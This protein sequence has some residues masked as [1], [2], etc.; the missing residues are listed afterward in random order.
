MS[1]ENEK[2]VIDT[3]RQCQRNWDL[4]KEIPNEHIQHWKY[5]AKHSPSKQDEGYYNVRII[6][7]RELIDELKLH[8]WGQSVKV[9]DLKGVARNPQMGA[10]VYILFTEK[11]SETQREID[12]AGNP[13]DLKDI[14]KIKNASVAAGI[15]GGLIAQSAASLGYRIGFNTNHSEPEIWHSKL[16]ILASKEN[17]LFGIGIGFPQEDKPRNETDETE[18]YIDGYPGQEGYETG[19]PN[20]PEGTKGTL[21]R[22]GSR[23]IMHDG[24]EHFLPPTLNYTTFSHLTKE[25]KVWIYE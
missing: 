21:V 18:F 7:N 16:R 8:T 23:S 24:K 11:L 14:V 3:I 25:I 15:A 19:L 5:I 2:R 12:I 9:G 13:I 17:L 10:S 1:L 20:Y 22:I 4:S 6:K